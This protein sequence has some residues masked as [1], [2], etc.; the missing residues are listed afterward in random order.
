MNEA[1][2]FKDTSIFCHRID[3]LQ[4]VCPTIEVASAKVVSTL[5]GNVKDIRIVTSGDGIILTNRGVK[6]A[7]IKRNF[8][9]GTI[10]KVRFNLM[11]AV[12]ICIFQKHNCYLMYA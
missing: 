5:N 3:T 8:F 9:T 1:K 4:Y 11:E 10:Y 12:K 6:A 2:L 7:H